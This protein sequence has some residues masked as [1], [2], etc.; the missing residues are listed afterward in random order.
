MAENKSH[1]LVVDDEQLILESLTNLLEFDY[2]VHSADNGRAAL[3]MLQKYPI[4]VIMSDQRMPGMF[5]HEL[6]RESKKISP[7]TI[8][9]LLTGYSDL[10]SVMYSVNAG[11]IFRYINKPW[12]SDMILRVFETGVQMYDKLAEL[13]KQHQGAP[14]IAASAPGVKK[15]VH[16]EVDEKSGSVLFVGYKNHEV[17]SLSKQLEK[18]FE[19]LSSANVD[20]ALQ[21][22]AK[23]PVSVI[24]SDVKF[25]NLDGFDFLSTIKSEYPEI[26]TVILTEVVDANLAIRSIN[27]LNVYKYLT[28][29]IEQNS[30]EQI[31]VEAAAKN[32]TYKEM[33]QSNFHSA[34]VA[35]TKSDDSAAPKSEES[36]YRLKLRAAQA[37]LAKRVENK[38]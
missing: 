2:S 6:L 29:P 17:D 9:V 19:V 32:R 16:I 36:I 5:G 12:K 13:T 23:K 1:I 21:Q 20:E 31:L 3:E 34:S 22:I 4:K 10:E 8:R 26:V 24:V 25:E 38:G 14:A 7:N 37:A 33:P 18:R 35:L 28:K 11:E 30:L 27:E 15:T